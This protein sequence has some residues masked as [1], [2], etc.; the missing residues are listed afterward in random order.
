MLKPAAQI[1]FL[2]LLISTPLLADPFLEDNRPLQFSSG[3]QQV[4]LIELYT[5]EG[6]SSCPPADRWMSQLKSNPSLW[7]D[8]N[9]I[10]FHVDYWDYIGWHDEFAEREF[11]ERQRRYIDEGAA[12]FVYTPGL[13][14]NGDEWQGWRAATPPSKESETVGA[15]T[16]TVD[17]P[18]LGAHFSAAYAAEDDLLLHVAI[19]GMNLETEVRA[20]ENKGKTLYHDFVVV[21]LS[22]VELKYVDGDYIAATQISESA[23]VSGDRAIVAWVSSADRQAPIQ[24]VGGFLP[25]T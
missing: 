10:A 2:A 11:G 21:G 22:S 18:K 5:S 20:G 7:K 17:G 24:S 16:L 9:P 6:C 14:R 1:A 3:E 15:L 13:F 25:S 12:R 19:L 23:G 8:F 4:A